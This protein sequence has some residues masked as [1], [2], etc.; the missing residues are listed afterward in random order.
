MPSPPMI[1]VKFPCAS[2]RRPATLADGHI[3]AARGPCSLLVLLLPFQGPFHPFVDKTHHQD[4]QKYHH[5]DEAECTD[6]L[7]HDRPGEKKSN[8]KIEEY[9]QDGNEVIAHIEFHACVLKCL[10]TAFIGRQFFIVRPVWC[11]QFT[12]CHRDYAHRDT[13][14]DEQQ[15]REI[16]FQHSISLPL[17]MFREL[18]QKY[19]LFFVL[20]YRHA[21][22]PVY[23]IFGAD[24][25]TRTP[26]PL[27]AQAP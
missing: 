20:Y 7:E 14:T 4:G 3:P 27:R 19:L 15:H 11:C 25:E 16:I 10:K 6:F 26:T 9:E 13:D 12:K 18:T 2:Y 21:G 23:F 8:F 5:G 1:A 22:V 17:R 24:G